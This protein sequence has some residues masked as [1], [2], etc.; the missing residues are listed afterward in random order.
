MFLV[1]ISSFLM[2]G[3]SSLYMPSTAIVTFAMVAKPELSRLPSRFSEVSQS[4]CSFLRL[5][6]SFLTRSLI[7]RRSSCVTSS[8]IWSF[9]FSVLDL[10]LDA[11]PESKNQSS[12]RSVR[13]V[14]APAIR[15]QGLSFKCPPPHSL[16]YVVSPHQ[17]LKDLQL[18][19]SVY[20][21]T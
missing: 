7:F 19:Q 21:A 2:R 13:R 5:S 20:S 10:V 3:S 11:R 12:S 8:A 14:Y 18:L 15:R 4:V 1:F 9:P 6:S 17:M 16:S